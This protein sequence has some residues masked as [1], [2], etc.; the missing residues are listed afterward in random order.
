MP[1]IA[2]NFQTTLLPAISQ[3]EI[4][5][6]DAMA[7][8]SKPSGNVA[9]LDSGRDYAPGICPNGSKNRT[10]A[11]VFVAVSVIVTQASLFGKAPEG[12]LAAHLRAARQYRLLRQCAPYYIAT[13]IH[14]VEAM[15]RQG[16]LTP[17]GDAACANRLWITWSLSRKWRLRPAVRCRFRSGPLY[18]RFAGTGRASRSLNFRNAFA[19]SADRLAIG[20]LPLACIFGGALPRPAAFDFRL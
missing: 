1:A 4:T 15:V 17:K 20:S 12:C 14:D 7:S 3:N 18:M 19:G 8:K 5:S 9:Y 13:A 6:N 11:K 10:I 16:S 2:A